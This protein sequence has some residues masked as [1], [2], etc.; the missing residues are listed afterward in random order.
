MNNRVQSNRQKLIHRAKRNSLRISIAIV[1]AFL[2][3]WAPYYITMLTLIFLNPNDEYIANIQLGIFFFGMSNSVVNP[4]I[5]GA[6]QL[7]PH[8]KDSSTHTTIT[9]YILYIYNIANF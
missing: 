1:T 2:I 3:C 8:R 7:M 9:R 6:F 4:L 5:Y